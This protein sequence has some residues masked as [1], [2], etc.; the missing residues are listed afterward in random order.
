MVVIATVA[1]P[2]V[3]L[4]QLEP[5]SGDTARAE[6]CYVARCAPYI[7]R[8][9]LRGSRRALGLSTAMTPPSL[10]RAPR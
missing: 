3:A 1:R 10:V 5:L 2:A 9:F 6:S 4:H 8:G 7:D